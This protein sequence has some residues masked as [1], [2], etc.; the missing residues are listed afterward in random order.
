MAVPTSK[1]SFLYCWTDNVKSMLY[2]GVHKGNEDDGYI[3]SS[4]YLNKE[5][6]ERPDDF[7][8]QIIAHGVRNDIR[9]LEAAVLKSINAAS[10]LSFY[11]KSNSDGKFYCDGHSLETRQKMS[12]TWKTKKKWNCDNSKA[13]AA[14]Q[15]KSHTIESREK[16]KTAQVKHSENRSTRMSFNNPMKNPES[17]AKMLE[18]RKINRELKNGNPHR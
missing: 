8:R 1:E 15:G 4:K 6:K 12:N 7:T 16:M 3:S 17:I 9:D 11:N 10:D 14:W 5:Y 13:I 18:T 2:V